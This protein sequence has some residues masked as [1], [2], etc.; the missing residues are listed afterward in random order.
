L[1]ACVRD[2]FIDHKTS[3]KRGA[4]RPRRLR[5]NASILGLYYPLG[6][7]PAV[8][9][10]DIVP[11]GLAEAWADKPVSAIDGHDVHAVVDEARKHGGE[12]RAR[13]LCLHRQ[14]TQAAFE[15]ASSMRR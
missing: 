8:T 9:E 5:E 1:A 4:K 3:P 14:W 10:P 7:D 13:R 12:N 6:S 11:A 15:L 2:F